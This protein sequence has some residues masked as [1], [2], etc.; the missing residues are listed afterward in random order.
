MY[1]VL[2][3]LASVYCTPVTRMH[4][5]ASVWCLCWCSGVI[6]RPR[7]VQYSTDE[8]SMSTKRVAAYALLAPTPQV[9]AASTEVVLTS[10]HRR[11]TIYIDTM[12]LRFVSCCE[13]ALVRIT[14]STPTTSIDTVSGSIPVQLVGVAGINARGL[15]GS[16]H[17]FELP[18]AHIA[19]A[20][21]VELYPVQFAFAVLGAR[22][23]FDDQNL[24]RFP[25]GS[26]IPFASTAA[27]FP[28]EVV[29]GPCIPGAFVH[30]PVAPPVR[31]HACAVA[32]NLKLVW[33]RLGFPYDAQWRA[34]PSASRGVL[35]GSHGRALAA[36]RSLPPVR[37]FDEPAVLRGRLH[38]LP[39]FREIHSTNEHAPG[40]KVFMDSCGPLVAS[41]RTQHRHFMGCVC[42]GSGY[43]VLLPCLSPTAEAAQQCL[44]LFI[45]EMRSLIGEQRYLS[46]LVIRTDNGSAFIA[47]RFQEFV[48]QSQSHL[49][50]SSPYCPNQ[51]SNAERLWGTRFATARVLLAA[52][53]L[54]P[55]FHVHAVLHAN[56]LHNRL[57]A[58]KRGGSSPFQLVSARLPD[59]THVRAFGCAAAVFQSKE[60]RRDAVGMKKLS[61]NRALLGVYLGPA[62]RTPGH[63][64]Y[65]PTRGRFC[66]AAHVAFD[67]SSFPGMFAFLPTAQQNLHDWTAVLGRA[68]DAARAAREDE[69]AAIASNDADLAAASA[70]DTTDVDVPDA[71][72][73]LRPPVAPSRL[74]FDAAVS[75]ADAPEYPPPPAPLPPVLESVPHAPAPCAPDAS[76]PATQPSRGLD[77]AAWAPIVAPRLGRDGR[78]KRGSAMA[79]LLSGV[80]DPAVAGAPRSSAAFAYV[81]HVTAAALP[82][83]DFS[84]GDCR[85][86][87]GY[88]AA[89]SSPQREYWEESIGAEWTGLLSR[90]TLDFIKRSEVP[91][92]SNI[93]RCHY[94]FDLKPRPDGSIEK[95]KARLVAD[96]NSQQ[97][98]VD[99]DSVFATVV[100]M[101]SVRA[102]LVLA[103]AHDWGLWQLD[104]KQAFLEADVHDD[105]YMYPPPNI[106]DRDA[107][108]DKIVCKLKKSLYGL[109][110]A[111]REW[112]NKLTSTLL[113]FGFIQSKIDTCV[114][115]FRAADSASTLY[116]SVYVDD[117]IL[118][119]S[120]EQTRRQFIAYITSILPIDDRGEL[121]WVLR[122]H[123]TR[124]RPARTIVLSQC[125]YLDKILEKYDAWL[126]L[127][128]TYDAPMDVQALGPEDSPAPDSPEWHSLADRRPGYIALVGA[129]LWLAGGTRPDISY[130]MSVLAR[131]VSNPGHA[132]LRAL[133]RV[134]AYLAGTRERVL[135]YAPD[136]AAPLTVFSDASWAVRNSVSGGIV[137]LY[138]CCVVWW[139]RRQHSVSLSSAEAEYM[140]ATVAGREAIYMRDLL[141]SLG[142]PAS[143]PTPLLLDS[144]SA[145]DLAF[146]P[147]AFKKTKHVL[148][149]A[150]WLRDVVA[151]RFLHPTFVP[152][153]DQ[154]ADVLTKALTP[155]LHRVALR[156]LLS[157]RLAV[158]PL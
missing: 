72:V 17:Y 100:R 76:V 111:A 29:Y 3:L 146:D 37:R 151:R 88:K 154:L 155:A 9:P 158:R 143:A 34:V 35:S 8:Q 39:L 113:D 117:I 31:L 90:D 20:A 75:S 112:A 79:A 144:K 1:F 26:C 46:P 102:L 87:R 84:L 36:G 99:F 128:R 125:Q 131:F 82:A 96:G 51:N 14:D 101:S 109:R 69:A 119:Y 81:A 120:D 22:H 94:V 49:T 56:W 70:S 24:I 4:G 68:L 142:F 156:R 54:P 73:V 157:D 83:P 52:A 27:G 23:A 71:P 59:F 114:Y 121:D 104:V 129:L 44:A 145:I 89:L 140:A 135:S 132:H 122:M 2:S 134:L 30:H 65:V 86:P 28:L 41:V 126:N 43:A 5:L 16:W 38:A 61:P 108:G 116:C 80:D 91:S 153:A 57:P 12:A 133:L 40:A 147:V 107:D 15:D 150:Y 63:V 67:E 11:A 47:S 106:S 138:G 130:A 55:R 118:A 13:L 93:M 139:S 45:A 58:L 110:Q 103:A 7:I 85:I 92:G 141:D 53:R 42:A 98:G 123:I 77:G 149:H 148:R 48:D 33:H 21:K 95:F 97:Q 74:R 127:A 19:R 32:P 18:D 137:L 50:F 10:K 6:A 115:V 25:D 64:V 152:T 60:Q 136:R 105:L 62:Q 78:L 124:D 66:I